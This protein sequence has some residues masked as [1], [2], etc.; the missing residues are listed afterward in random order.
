MHRALRPGGDVAELDV[1]VRCGGRA[2]SVDERGR[3]A[4]YMAAASGFDDAVTYLLSHGA[5]LQLAAVDGR[6]PLHAAAAAGHVSTVRHL[7]EAAIA[8]DAERRGGSSALMRAMQAL[9]ADGRTAADVATAS[10]H[11]YVV[12]E[13]I[14]AHAR[15]LSSMSGGGGGGAVG[16]RRPQLRPMTWEHE[17]AHSPHAEMKAA[18]VVA[19]GTTA[20]PPSSCGSSRSAKAASSPVGISGVAAAA[21]VVGEM[22]IA[23]ISRGYAPAWASPVPH[24]LMMTPARSAAQGKGSAFNRIRTP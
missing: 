13:M 18:A 5:D 19:A 22:E 4:L 12:R 14:T 8:Q 16:P 11:M 15:Y 3:T 21:D 17:L 7:L 24:Q 20:S 1:L 10:R 2:D 6:T 23:R 9:D